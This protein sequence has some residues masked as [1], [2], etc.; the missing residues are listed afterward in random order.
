MTSEEQARVERYVKVKRESD[1]RMR[2]LRCGGDHN[3]ASTAEAA[4]SAAM[5]PGYRI[6]SESAFPQTPVHCRYSR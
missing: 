4:Y 1:H 5:S 2:P 6:E 3:I